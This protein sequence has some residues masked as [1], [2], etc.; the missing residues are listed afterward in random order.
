[1]LTPVFWQNA[2]S[3]NYILPMEISVTISAEYIR[4]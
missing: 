3:G 1:M 2:G 4:L